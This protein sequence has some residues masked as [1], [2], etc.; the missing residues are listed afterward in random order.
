M[1]AC[2]L[3]MWSPTLSRL[4]MKYNDFRGGNVWKGWGI[5]VVTDN[6]RVSWLHFFVIQLLLSAY[7]AGGGCECMFASGS[8][9]M[10]AM[11][12]CNRHRFVML[13]TDSLISVQGIV[14]PCLCQCSKV[15]LFQVLPFVLV[16]SCRPDRLS[17]YSVWA[18]SSLEI[19][20]C[21]PS[22]C[23]SCENKSILIYRYIYRF[24]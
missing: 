7:A 12:D 16:R 18:Y 14:V 8:L 4:Q 3:K 21:D 5:L 2:R 10:I 22:S 6:E 15:C 19:A 13:H 23:R 24:T 17:V 11:I 1:P 20:G 9:C